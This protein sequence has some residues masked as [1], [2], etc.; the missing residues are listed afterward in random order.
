VL[1]PE[2]DA[3]KRIEQ[4]GKEAEVGFEANWSWFC[5]IMYRAAACAQRTDPIRFTSMMRRN[6]AAVASIECTHPTIPA[7]QQSMLMLPMRS[8]ASAKA[9]ETADSEVTSQ[10][11]RWMGICGNSSARASIWLAEL[12]S[13]EGRSRSESA[14]HP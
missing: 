13:V 8:M 5:T 1:C 14:E 9:I 4:P 10:A 2:M 6:S 12:P 11:M 3:V 7:K